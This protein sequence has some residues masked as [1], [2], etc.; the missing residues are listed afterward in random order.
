MIFRSETNCHFVTSLLL[1]LT[2]GALV[3]APLATAEVVVAFDE[4][5][6]GYACTINGG[7]PGYPGCAYDPNTGTGTFVRLGSGLSTDPNTGSTNVLTYKLPN[8]SN[9]D[10]LA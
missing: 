8:F 4:W 6:K 3:F 7:Q 5:G 2:L 9:L 10:V 1:G